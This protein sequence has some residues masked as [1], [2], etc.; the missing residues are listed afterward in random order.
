MEGEHGGCDGPAR[1]ADLSTRPAIE[2]AVLAGSSNS[3]AVEPGHGWRREQAVR[4]AG[5]NPAVQ[6]VGAVLKAEQQ[7]AI[8]VFI[9]DAGDE[10][11]SG[12]VLAFERGEIDGAPIRCNDGL[13]AG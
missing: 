7:A 5:V 9:A 12:V 2:R 4:Y 3:R 10:A 11:T 13:S 6:S 1:P 8:A